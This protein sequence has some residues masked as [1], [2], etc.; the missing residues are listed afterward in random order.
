VSVAL[1]GSKVSDNLG[2]DFEAFG[3]RR[4]ALSGTAGTNN[5]V[6]IEFHGTSKRIDV[7]TTASLPVDPTGTDTVTVIR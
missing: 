4:D 3:A 7:L 6:T 2:N 5:N 1:W